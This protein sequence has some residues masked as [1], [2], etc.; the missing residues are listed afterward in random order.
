MQY[1]H[2]KE[3]YEQV[4]RTEIIMETERKKELG[5][6]D[7][8]VAIILSQSNYEKHKNKVLTDKLD[9]YKSEISRLTSERANMELKYTTVIV[10]GTSIAVAVGWIGQQIHNNF[11]ASSSNLGGISTDSCYG[12]IL[13]AEEGI[14]PS[15]LSY[16]TSGLLQ[17]TTPVSTVNS[18]EVY[19]ISGGLYGTH[20]DVSSHQTYQISQINSQSMS[21]REPSIAPHFESFYSGVCVSTN[22][23]MN[24]SPAIIPISE[25]TPPQIQQTYYFPWSLYNN[26]WDSFFLHQ[27]K[28]TTGVE[29][30]DYMQ[31]VLEYFGYRV[32][33]TN[34]SCDFGADLILE[35]NGIKT[36]VQLKQWKENVGKDA[37]QQAYAAKD[38]HKAAFARVICTSKFTKSALEL[39]KTLGVECWDGYQLIQE[40]YKY[41]YFYPPTLGIE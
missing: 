7:E 19:Q 16:T 30:E 2:Q 28:K 12:N 10:L 32:T 17:G 18:K 22:I 3:L 4:T 11:M 37:I 15:N 26:P 23:V 36:V 31:R 13:I 24:S 33:R 21:Y 5:Q 25:Y 40:L 41:G 8:G 9:K 38:Y 20:C 29:F 34:P 39:A 35:W 27:I 14:V 1:D 6:I